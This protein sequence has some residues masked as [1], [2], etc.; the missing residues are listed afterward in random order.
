MILAVF[1]ALCWTFLDVV[2][3]VA[4][5]SFSPVE[6]TVAMSIALTIFF[7]LYCFLTS[8]FQISYE[9]ILYALIGNI[10]GLGSNYLI[11][12]SLGVGTLS[13]VVPLFSLSSLWSTV[14]EYF[15]GKE[16]TQS[17]I[18]AMVCIII[19][20]MVLFYEGYRE[21]GNARRVLLPMFLVG[22]FLGFTAFIDRKGVG[23][24]TPMSWGFLL[25]SLGLILQLILFRKHLRSPEYYLSN[26]KV[27]LPVMILICGALFFQFH[28]LEYISSGVLETIKRGIYLSGGIL[29]AKF[30]F[31]EHISRYKIVS[32]VFMI[33]GI[34]LA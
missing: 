28:S 15:L 30:Y 26:M 25:T 10:F 24:S 33:I 4:A 29:F 34:S 13:M 20:G 12:W 31:K 1:C 23:L 3:K 32:I 8:T 5:K 27:I 7:S 21:K 9:L 6:V 14:L 16:P 19:G 2:R 11:S 17:E 18:I 22:I